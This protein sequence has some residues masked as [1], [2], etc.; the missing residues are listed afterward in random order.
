MRVSQSNCLNIY[1]RPGTV[2]TTFCDELSDTVD[3]LIASGQSFVTF[4]DFNSPGSGSDLLDPKLSDIFN[5]NGITQH[6]TTS[7]HELEHTLD[8]IVTSDVHVNLVA[9]VRGRTAGISDHRLVACRLSLRRHNKTRLTYTYRN[10]KF[11]DVKVFCNCVRAPRPYDD[12]A[13]SMFT[14]DAYA[15]LINSW[16]HRILT[17]S[18]L[19]EPEPSD[20]HEMRADVRQKQR[21]RQGEPPESWSAVIYVHD[22]NRIGLRTVQRHYL[23]TWYEQD[24][25]AHRAAPLSTYMIWTE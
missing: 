16:T 24:R 18:L 14:V 3:E 20:S 1:R 10:I 17:T 22:M 11:I 9:D 5:D 15:E 19:W 8:L 7:T 12:D 25:P 2:S 4:G 23:R 13:L 21:V 6:V